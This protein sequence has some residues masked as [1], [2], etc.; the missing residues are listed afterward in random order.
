M[1]ACSITSSA[2]DRLVCRQHLCQHA[3]LVLLDRH[4]QEGSSSFGA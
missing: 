2:K 4:D 3:E 1:S